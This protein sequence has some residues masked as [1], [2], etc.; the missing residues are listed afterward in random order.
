MLDAFSL[1]ESESR[2]AAEFM[3]THRERHRGESEGAIGGRFTYSFTPT[4]IGVL[5]SIAC[6]CGEH[7]NLTG[8]E[9]L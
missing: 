5:A 6:A 7:E 3:R 4:G 1:S 9:D 2:K 8:W